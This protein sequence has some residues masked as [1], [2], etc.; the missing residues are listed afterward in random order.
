MLLIYVVC[1]LTALPSI[2]DYYHKYEHRQYFISPTPFTAVSQLL[3]IN[4]DYSSNAT[5]HST[6]N[7]ALEASRCRDKIVGL[8]AAITIGEW[9]LETIQA[10]VHL[11][12]TIYETR[13]FL[14]GVLEVSGGKQNGDEYWGVRSLGDIDGSGGSS[15][16]GY[17]TTTPTSGSSK[18]HSTKCPRTL[19]QSGSALKFSNINVPPDI[20]IR[21]FVRIHEIP[22]LVG[23]I[24]IRRKKQY[25]LMQQSANTPDSVP[26]V[27]FLGRIRLTSQ[28]SLMKLREDYAIHAQCSLSEINSYPT[29]VHATWVRLARMSRF[30]LF[31][32]RH[33]S[34]TSST[35]MP[36]EVALLPILHNS[37]FFGKGVHSCDICAGKTESL[38]GIIFLWLASRTRPVVAYR[39]YPLEK[40]HRLL[41][42]RIGLTREV[43]ADPSWGLTLRIAAS[44]MRNFRC[45]DQAR[46]DLEIS[47]RTLSDLAP[48]ALERPWRLG[49]FAV[50]HPHS[51]IISEA[52]KPSI[53]FLLLRFLALTDILTLLLAKQSSHRLRPNVSPAL[54]IAVF[55]HSVKPPAA[56]VKP[57]QADRNPATSIQSPY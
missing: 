40:V 15:S 50:S 12:M 21:S 34:I 46:P 20:A 6:S 8:N 53:T 27:L 47:D 33:I 32:S 43:T 22:N 2:I 29:A 3:G 5:T 7:L 26:P 1:P 17:G 52:V 42:L 51:H 44:Y 10:Y 30:L 9:R 18:R 35:V 38:T 11:G 39:D 24:I 37:F 28:L 54:E 41:A 48:E 56:T 55:T 14:K 19:T 49:L 13:R 4:R 25:V 57:R 16:G 23:E 45:L 36:Q 31:V